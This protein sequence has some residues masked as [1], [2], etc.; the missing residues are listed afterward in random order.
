MKQTPLRMLAAG[1]LCVPCLAAAQ[2]AVGSEIAAKSRLHFERGVQSYNDGSLNS[3]L[4]EF[5]RA[6]E[7]T[8]DYRLLYNVAQVQAERHDCV[9]AI[10]TF[11]DYLR[12]G[13]GAISKERRAEVDEETA[14]LRQRVGEFWVSANVP[15]AEV[16][17]GDHLA[18][19]LP[20]RSPVLLNA[21]QAVIRIAHAGHKSLHREIEI[22]GGDRVRLEVH[23]EVE[24]SGVS[25]SVSEPSRDNTW[26]WGSLAATGALTAGSVIFG[27]LARDANR[28]LDAWMNLYPSNSSGIQDA[29]ATLRMDAMICDVLAGGAVL[30]AGLSL[31]LAL[32]PE[33]PKSPRLGKATSLGTRARLVPS[34]TGV[35]L[36]GDF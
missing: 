9:R 30:G 15:G 24:S 13:G 34:P 20:L 12:Q 4:A 21:G 16:W 25:A 35:L 17:V 36:R 19:K 14:R 8:R 27:F 22:A 1:L 26:L 28:A 31:Y 6:Y 32:S 11:A 18:A 33:S 23:L 10:E 29:R 2:T 5:K 3:A 7:L